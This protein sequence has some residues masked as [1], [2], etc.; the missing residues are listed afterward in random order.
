VC[1]VCFCVCAC[2]CVF[3]LCLC[4]CVRACVRLC[5]RACVR[6]CVSVHVFSDIRKG[7][8]MTQTI[9][10]SGSVQYLSCELFFVSAVSLCFCGRFSGVNG[11]LPEGECYESGSLLVSYSVF[12][13]SG[14]FCFFLSQ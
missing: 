13:F 11:Q 2:V 10:F 14:W 1:Y 5:V 3:A 12:W 8:G 7:I 9:D 6:V 4:A